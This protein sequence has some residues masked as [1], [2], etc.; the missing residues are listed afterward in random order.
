MNQS[1]LARF[2][3]IGDAKLWWKQWCRDEGVL[4]GCSQ[5]WEN[6]NNAVKGRYLP[7]AHEAIKINEFFSLKQASLT[8]EEYYSKFVTLRRYAPAL[9]SDQQV[10]RFCQLSP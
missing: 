10:V 9:T 6:V 3:L 5:S 7:P 4:E 8:L 2:R 1:M